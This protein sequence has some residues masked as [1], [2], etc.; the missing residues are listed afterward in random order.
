MFADQLFPY[1]KYIVFSNND[2][3]VIGKLK[4]DL[5]KEFFSN[6]K[7]CAVVGPNIINK[8]DKKTISPLKKSSIWKELFIYYYDCLTMHKLLKKYCDFVEE[9]NRTSICEA[10]AGSFLIV[11]KCKFFISGM[12]DKNTFLYYEELILAARTKMKRYENWFFLDDGF[13]LIHEH[14]VTVKKN[15]F[16]L[17][18]DIISFKSRCYYLRKYRDVNKFLLRLA[19]LNFWLIFVP[20]ALLKFF[21]KSILKKQ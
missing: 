18:S 4:W 19:Q 10:V 13:Q 1:D 14:N 8:S 11:D 2:L 15:L 5:I 17:K 3:E 7:K 20:I 12:Y 16:F 9:K 6:H 21:I